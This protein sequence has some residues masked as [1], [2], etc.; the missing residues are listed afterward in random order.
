MSPPVFRPDPT[1]VRLAFRSCARGLVLVILLL[2]AGLTVT[3]QSS[4]GATPGAV[5]AAVNPNASFSDIS[6]IAHKYSVVILNAWQAPIM[7]ALKAANPAIT[8]L[9]YKDLSDTIDTAPQGGFTSTGINYQTAAALDPDW[10]LL[11]RA[12]QRIALRNY[13]HEWAMDIGSASY[14][15]AWLGAVLGELKAQGWDGV[16]LDNVNPTI[17]Y[18]YD[19]AD[20]AK[21]PTDTAYQT[22]MTSAIQAIAPPIRAAGFDVVA[23]IGSWTEYA[24]VGNSWLTYLTGAMDEKFVKYAM[25]PGVGYSSQVRWQSELASIELASQMGKMFLGITVADASDSQATGFGLATL[26]LGSNG[27]AAFETADPSAYWQQPAAIPSVAGQIGAP[28]APESAD[29]DGVHRRYFSSGIVLVNPT[30]MAQQVSLGGDYVVPG[31]LQPISATT[32]APQTGLILTRAVSLPALGLP[33]TTAQVP[34]AAAQVPSTTSQITPVAVPVSCSP[35]AR[36]GARRRTPTASA[37]GAHRRVTAGSRVVAHDK[38]PSCSATSSGGQADSPRVR[39]P[40]SWQLVGEG[41]LRHLHQLLG[42]Q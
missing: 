39:G 12:G 24:A 9:V 23:N 29:P 4:A 28:L 21:Y 1:A 36:G 15:Q 26:L 25:G 20:V 10:F 40:H 2:L 27:N 42:P 13:P 31:S 33:P 5:W 16:F 8:V 14:Q 22:A 34:S 19:P 37:R 7:R 38:M 6:G 18:Y 41:L 35:T 3:A 11:D 17:K 30:A 32:L